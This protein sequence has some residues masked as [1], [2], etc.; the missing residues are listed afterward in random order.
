M[1]RSS[2]NLKSSIF[3]VSLEH[4]IRGCQMDHGK[5]LVSDKSLSIYRYAIG[6][7]V[8]FVTFGLKISITVRVKNKKSWKLKKLS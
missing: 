5:R 4:I 2:R 8:W 6:I 7:T 3:K 1:N